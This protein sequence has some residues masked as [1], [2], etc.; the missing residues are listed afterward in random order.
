MNRLFF[1]LILP[2]PFWVSA[3][4]Q[5]LVT[6]GKIG[7]AIS[8]AAGSEAEGT[9]SGLNADIRFDPANPATARIFATLQTNTF[10]TGLAARDNT[11]RGSNYFDVAKYPQISMKLIKA[12][13]ISA[14]QYKGTFELTIKNVSKIMEIPFTVDSSGTTGTFRASFQINRLE[15]GIGEKSW[16]LGDVAKV[17]INVQVKQS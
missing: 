4:P 3:Q 13:A 2:L 15:Y 1:L 16:M 17:S 5:W 8:H 11:M 14:N 10:N 9:F 7:F 6:G 12:V